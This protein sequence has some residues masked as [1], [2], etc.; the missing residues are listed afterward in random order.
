MAC[1]L[2]GSKVKITKYILKKLVPLILF[3]LVI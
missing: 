2:T 1:S 3:L